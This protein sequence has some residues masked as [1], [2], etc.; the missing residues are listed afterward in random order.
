V[1]IIEV[2]AVPIERFGSIGVTM[3]LTTS[4]PRTRLVTD[5]PATLAVAELAAGGVIG[6]HPAVGPQLLTVVTGAVEVSGGDGQQRRLAAGEAVLFEPGEQH[7][8]TAAE[9]ATLAIVEWT[10]SPA[11]PAS[12]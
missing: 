4:A 3:H 12:G 7:E 8:T 6:R 11:P 5:G 1:R 9:P 10:G 2:D